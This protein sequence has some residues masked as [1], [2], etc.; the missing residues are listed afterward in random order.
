MR[1]FLLKIII[2]TCLMIYLSTNCTNKS[3]PKP[4]GYFR[5]EFPEKE[6]VLF[7]SVM[8]YTFLYPKYARIEPDFSRNSEPYWINIV[9]PEFNAKIHV[10]YKNLMNE[11]LYLILEDV[12]RLSFN[13][14][15]KA[16]AI[17]EQVYI[18][19]ENNVYGTL[20][21]VRGN[22]A[23]PL[24]FFATD[25]VKRFIYGS[26]YFFNTPNRDSLAPVI[27]FINKDVLVLMEN[28]RWKY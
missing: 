20:F 28:I 5:I 4:R 17:E 27:D 11:D 1:F 14:T 7:D 22:A 13:H 3:A 2:G 26:L 12:I 9:F 6:Y 24:Q 23:S 21:E 10:T 18:D 8:P 15:I 19:D 25:S 16:D